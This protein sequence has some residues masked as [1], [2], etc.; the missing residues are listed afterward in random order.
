[1]KPKLILCFIILFIG[2]TSCKSNQEKIDCEN[3][4]IDVKKYI[5][6]IDFEAYYKG[7]FD[8]TSF[9]NINLSSIIKT[10][11]TD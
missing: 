11:L 5:L 4:N 6:S 9:Y 8:E 7:D 2:I 1:M 10:Q 3:E